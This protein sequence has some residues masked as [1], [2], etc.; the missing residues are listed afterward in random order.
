MRK[1][2]SGWHGHEAAIEIARAYEASGQSRRAFAHGAGI[3]T[4][5]LDNYRKR[6]RQE[7]ARSRFVAVDM[8]AP[9]AWG[10]G[11]VAVVLPT[12]H[13]VEVADGFTAAT[14]ERLLGVLEG[15]S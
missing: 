5:T 2:R 13:R 4:G 8:V 14:L 9:Q 1:S 3:S 7:D 6:A 15:R 12:G 11:A 10:K